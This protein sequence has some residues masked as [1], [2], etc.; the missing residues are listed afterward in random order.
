M[1]NALNS[2]GR[3][4]AISNGAETRYQA[5]QTV[6]DAPMAAAGQQHNGYNFPVRQ[7]F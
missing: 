4:Q 6:D 3:L 1:N 5:G 7:A 2:P